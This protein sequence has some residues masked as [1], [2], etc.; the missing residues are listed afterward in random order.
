LKRLATIALVLGG[1]VGTMVPASGSAAVHFPLS[2]IGGDDGFEIDS[3]RATPLNISNF[4]NRVNDAAA[5]WSAIGGSGL[6]FIADGQRTMV[7]SLQ[8]GSVQADETWVMDFWTD[9][10]TWNWPNNNGY[11]GCVTGTT[12]ISGASGQINRALIRVND[13]DQISWYFLPGTPPSTWWDLLSTLTHEFGHA[14]GGKGGPDFGSGSTECVNLYTIC[15][16]ASRGTT[17]KRSI[18]PHEMAD[19]DVKY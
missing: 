11:G 13:D 18:T 10:T 2:N 5:A 19:M 9:N 6:D 3:N 14:A 16:G 15:G 1:L 17:W 8:V 12:T 4:V 7:S